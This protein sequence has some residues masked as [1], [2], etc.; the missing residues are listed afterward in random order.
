MFARLQPGLLADHAFAAWAGYNR[1]VLRWVAA[2]AVAAVI[3]Y[4]APDY[5]GRVRAAARG[6]G[7]DAS[8]PMPFR[9]AELTHQ[10]A[11]GPVPETLMDLWTAL[12]AAA[13]R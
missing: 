3:D 11:G 7:L 9:E 8:R 1:A 10:H 2:G 13:D 6:L 4:D 12:T 5:D